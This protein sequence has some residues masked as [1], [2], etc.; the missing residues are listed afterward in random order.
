M[1]A[2]VINERRDTKGLVLL[3]D[4]SLYSISKTAVA[5]DEAAAVVQLVVDRPDEDVIAK[6]TS[7]TKYNKT[8]TS[9]SI[10]TS[11]E[12]NVMLPASLQEV[13]KYRKQEYHFFY[14]TPLMYRQLTEPYIQTI[15]PATN[16]WIDDYN[17]GVKEPLMRGDDFF[18]VPDVKWDMKDT[19]LF[20]GIC[21]SEDPSILSIR[22]LRRE[23]LPLLHRM[24]EN[25]LKYIESTTKLSADKVVVYCHYHPS[26][27]HFHVHFTSTL[28][29]SLSRN[30]AIGK[31]VPLD[32]IIQNIEYKTDYYAEATLP[33]SL[34]TSHVLHDAFVN[35]K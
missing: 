35:A 18:L 19:N 17:M 23:H 24:K 4:Q 29:P 22:S 33:V 30:N 1:S 7:S 34:G 15:E 28:F 20:Y 10:S 3:K 8:V 21:F 13:N 12:V 32:T 14:E 9:G 27:W 5:T 6:T 25:V 2:A 11:Y 16:K 31:A 26:F